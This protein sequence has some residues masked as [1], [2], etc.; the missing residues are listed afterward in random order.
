MFD[1]C[2]AFFHGF[3]SQHSVL[4]HSAQIRSMCFGSTRL[5]DYSSDICEFPRK[6]IRTMSYFAFYCCSLERAPEGADH[7][8]CTGCQPNTP[9]DTLQCFCFH[10]E[11]EYI[12]HRGEI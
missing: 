8:H 7:W 9:I 12:I 1:R 5:R 4:L 6:P 3:S 11:S 2:A 10:H